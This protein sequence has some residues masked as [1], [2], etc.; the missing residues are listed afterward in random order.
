MNA[1]E[2]VKIQ[3]NNQHHLHQYLIQSF[4]VEPVN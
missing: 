2:G 1:G 3:Y 4:G